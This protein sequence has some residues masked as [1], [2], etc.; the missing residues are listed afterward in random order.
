M[1]NLLRFHPYEQRLVS[2]STE[3]G[4]VT[5]HDTI[6]VDS[7]SSFHSGVAK[8]HRLT[9]C[10][11]VNEQRDSLLMLGSSD[12]V[13]RLW[14]D[15]DSAAPTLTT[16]WR[17]VQKMRAS[18]S[19]Q[20]A[21]L[22]LSWHQLTGHLLA[23][24]DVPYIQVRGAGE[25][26]RH[27]RGSRGRLGR[28]GG[29]SGGARNTLVLPGARHVCVLDMSAVLYS[30]QPRPLF[31][32]SF[33]SMVLGVGWPQRAPRPTDPNDDQQLYHVDGV[34]SVR[35]HCGA[36]RRTVWGQRRPAHRNRG[37]FISNGA[38]LSPSIALLLAPRRH[39]SVLFPP[40]SAG[41]GNGIVR[42]YD[43][44]C[45]DDRA[46]TQHYD[47]HKSW[48]VNVSQIAAGL[49]GAAR[50]RRA[51]ACSCCLRP[52]FASRTCLSHALGAHAKG[53]AA[54]D[55]QRLEARRPA[56]VGPALSGRAD[57][58]GAGAQVARR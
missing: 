14:R 32:L 27:T 44:R 52:T 33:L 42:L 37:G 41:Y 48:V 22:V 21:G 23:S 47:H 56:V 51:F 53:G 38:L 20:G 15:Y 17:V 6:V 39:L 18:Q 2:C 28:G 46:M 34:R 49:D 45:S 13:V 11:I 29:E 30:F 5:V 24:G 8:P 16:A 1:V 12:G 10:Q 57:A 3:S 36:C 54:A 35:R 55:Y 7:R 50:S 43:L 9:N 19:G 4:T 58:S 40:K 31:F 26:R 25:D